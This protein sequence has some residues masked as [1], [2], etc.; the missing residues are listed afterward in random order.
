MDCLFYSVDEVAN[1]F[2]KSTKWVYEAINKGLI[3]GAFKLNGSWFINKQTL[4]EDLNTKSKRTAKK[5]GDNTSGINRH[6]LIIPV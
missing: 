4:F 3:A 1:L 5:N 2:G 6:N